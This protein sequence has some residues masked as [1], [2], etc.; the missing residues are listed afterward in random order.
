MD[1]FCLFVHLEKVDEGLFGYLLDVV[2][3]EAAS[4][5]ERFIEGVAVAFFLEDVDVGEVAERVHDLAGLGAIG[6]F[7]SL[8]AGFEDLFLFS[9]TSFEITFQVQWRSFI[10]IL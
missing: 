1:E 2:F 3:R 5:D 6:I 7:I 4:D 8:E 9:K 10:L